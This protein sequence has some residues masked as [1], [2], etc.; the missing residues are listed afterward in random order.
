MSMRSY[1][2]IPI[3]ELVQ[4]LPSSLGATTGLRLRLVHKMR[5]FPGCRLIN[6]MR[7]IQAKPVVNVEKS[8]ENW[9][10]PRY[11]NIHG[12]VKYQIAILMRLATSYFD[13]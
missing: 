11:T 12:V 1:S 9:A 7:R 10:H 4:P 8:T 2:N 5:E 13:I 6:A 3:V